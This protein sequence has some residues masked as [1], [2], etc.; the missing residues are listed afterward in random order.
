MQSLKIWADEAWNREDEK[1]MTKIMRLQGREE[2]LKRLLLVFQERK[3][4][5][6]KYMK[7]MVECPVCG[8]HTILYTEEDVWECQG[9]DSKFKGLREILKVAD[10]SKGEPIHL[11]RR[12]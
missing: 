1:D 6:V 7:K 2:D 3:P 8:C 10:Q 9:C 4:E 12:R 5:W 11:L